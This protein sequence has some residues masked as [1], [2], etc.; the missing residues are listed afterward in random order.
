MVAYDNC[1]F[2]WNIQRIYFI[3]KNSS[4]NLYANT[5]R[6]CVRDIFIFPSDFLFEYCS[7]DFIIQ[8]VYQ[9]SSTFADFAVFDEEV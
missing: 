7:S 6:N 1:V 5:Q 9:C 8:I 3:R 4:S 2:R